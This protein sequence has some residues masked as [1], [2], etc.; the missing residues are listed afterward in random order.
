MNKAKQTHT[1]Q[2][3]RRKLRNLITNVSQSLCTN[4]AVVTAW[5]RTYVNPVSVF[6]EGCSHYFSDQLDRYSASTVTPEES[7]YLSARK[8]TC[9]VSP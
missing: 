5:M 4:Y 3:K 7:T 9:T 6:T 2:K 8:I 1:P